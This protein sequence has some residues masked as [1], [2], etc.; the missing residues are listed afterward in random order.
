MAPA[1]PLPLLASTVTPSSMSERPAAYAGR[2]YPGD[3]D[4]VRREV[5]RFL[6]AE[7]SEE[8]AVAVLV[9]HAAWRLV[10]P[11]LGAVFARIRIPGTVV[12]LGPNHGKVG[13]SATIQTRGRWRI[14]GHHVSV[15]SAMAED[16]RRVALLTEELRPH[17]EEHALEVLLPFLLAR[18]PKV[19]IVPVLFS[20]GAEVA[21][22]PRCTRIGSALADVVAVHGRDVLIVVSSDM[23]QRLPPQQLTEADEALSRCIEALDCRC[24]LEA[25]ERTDAQMCGVVPAAVGL[26][27]ARALGA[28]EAERVGHMSSLDGPDPHALPVGYAGFVFR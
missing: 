17:R 27:A 2:L 1:W 20:D 15:D 4:S 23:A 6:G 19:R 11:L 12:L 5:E 14:P 8:R 16:L 25:N 28:K 9:P 22:H 26:V 7:R 24:L 21:P 10:G 18:N 3:E 13:A